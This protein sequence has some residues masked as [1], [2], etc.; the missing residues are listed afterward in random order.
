AVRR[1]IDESP[2]LVAVLPHEPHELP[3]S[4]VRGFRPKKSLEAPAQV[5]AVP[6]LKSVTTGNNPVVT[7]GLEHGRS[8]VAGTIRWRGRAWRRRANRQPYLKPFTTKPRF[9]AIGT[10][11]CSWTIIHFAPRFSQIPV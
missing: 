10:E 5:G 1:P 4:H 2:H 8:Q 9:Y 11:R 3:R 7:K 6:R